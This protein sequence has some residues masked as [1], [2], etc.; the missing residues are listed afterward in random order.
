VRTSLTP[1][2]YHVLIEQSAAMIWRSD[3]LGRC[4]YFNDRWLAFTGRSLQ[5]EVGDGWAEGVHPDDM[6]RC[7]RVFRDALAC[8]TSFEMAYRLRRRDGE[9]RWLRDRGGPVFDA[10][11]QCTGFVGS[12]VDVTDWMPTHANVTATE[13][14]VSVIA[15][16]LPICAWCQKVRTGAGVWHPLE[17]FLRDHSDMQFTHC[18]CP[19]CQKEHG[20]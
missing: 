20:H 14:D 16:M 12:C 13:I 4:E 2:D 11:G 7:L 10:S 9:Y 15:A 3:R 1:E 8:G 19:E 6:E 5:Q 17:L 18:I